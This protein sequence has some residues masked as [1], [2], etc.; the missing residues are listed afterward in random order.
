MKLS[1]QNSKPGRRIEL[2][3]LLVFSFDFVCECVLMAK[4]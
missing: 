1:R 3:S 2:N 4:L